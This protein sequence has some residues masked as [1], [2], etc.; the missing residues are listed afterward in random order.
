M[1]VRVG[2]AV[3]TRA[4]GDVE[5]LVEQRCELGGFEPGQ[6]ERQQGDVARA[7]APQ[8]GVVGPVEGEAFGRLQPSHEEVD[9]SPLAPADRLDA[10][11]EHDT[12]SLAQAGDAEDVGRASFKA[13][14]QLLGLQR[15]R[16]ITSRAAVAPRSGLDALAHD[17]ATGAGRA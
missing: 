1:S 12:D 2:G 17:E 6:V 8:E 10:L 3:E 7:A 11:V 16:R 9:E 14:G 5:P 15:T 13:V 4:H